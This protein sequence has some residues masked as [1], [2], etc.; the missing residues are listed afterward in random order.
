MVNDNVNNN[1][2]DNV[3][4]IS[5]DMLRMLGTTDVM[6]NSKHLEYSYSEYSCLE[7]IAHHA[8]TKHS[9]IVI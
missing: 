9:I 3:H 8:T 5:V 2:N 1:V 4:P 6:D 7:F